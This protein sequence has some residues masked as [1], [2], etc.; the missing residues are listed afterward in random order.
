MKKWRYLLVVLLV[1]VIGGLAHVKVVMAE[2][3]IP[4][5][6]EYT[7]EMFREQ[8]PDGK[9]IPVTTYQEFLDAFG[10]KT[11]NDHVYIKVMN[12]LE[13]PTDSGPKY[14]PEIEPLGKDKDYRKVVVDG[15][16]G[17]GKNVRINAKAGAIQF[18]I[19]SNEWSDIVVQNVDIYSQNRSG[20]ISQ[21]YNSNDSQKL[22]MTYHNVDYYGDQALRADKSDVFFSGEIN[23]YG[24]QNYLYD[25]KSYKT[26]QK[27]GNF[28]VSNV[29]I[30]KKTKMHVYNELDGVLQIVRSNSTVTVGEAADVLFDVSDHP[31]SLAKDGVNYI[32]QH[33][34][35][36]GV[37]QPPILAFSLFKN[38][39]DL[40]DNPIQQSKLY[41]KD[42]SQ[43]KLKSDTIRQY[44]AIYMNGNDNLIDVGQ[45]ANLIIEHES[46]IGSGSNKYAKGRI[47]NINGKNSGVNVQEN[48]HFDIKATKRK[49]NT[50]SVFYGGDNTRLTVEPKGNFSISSDAN[51]TAAKGDT[52]NSLI[53]LGKNSTFNFNDANSVDL[54]YTDSQYSENLNLINMTT[55]SFDVNVQRVKAWA[56]GEDIENEGTD[57]FKEYSPMF[58]MKIPYK[59]NVVQNKDIIAA[60]TQKATIENFK[61]E[62][63]TTGG[64]GGFQRLKFEY[65]E[66]VS[67]DVT[68]QPT[69][70]TSDNQSKVIDAVATPGAHLRVKTTPVEGS[71]LLPEWKT[72]WNT[73][74]SPVESTGDAQFE[75]MTD[76]YTM[77][78]PSDGKVS[79]KLK[80]GTFNAGTKV[81]LYV[82][83]EGKTATQEI[84]VLDT[85]P[86]SGDKKIVNSWKGSNIPEPNRFVQHPTDTNPVPQEFQYQYVTDVNEEMMNEPGKHDVIVKLSDNAGNSTEINSELYIYDEPHQ[87]YAKDISVNQQDFKKALEKNKLEDW[88]IKTSEAGAYSIDPNTNDFV[89]LTNKITVK[90]KGKLTEKVEEGTYP[91]E[92]AVANPSMTKTINV[93]IHNKEVTMQVKQVYKGSDKP[94]YSNLKE[95]QTVKND[96]NQKQLIGESLSDVINKLVSDKK[97]ALNYDGYDDMS[98]KD[99]K[100][101]VDGKEV[102]TTQVPDKSFELVFEYQGK[103]TFNST[104]NVDFGDM[105]VNDYKKRLPKAE[106]KIQVINTLPDKT[107]QL[108]ASLPQGIQHNH[109]KK[110]FKGLMTYADDAGKETE[111]NQSGTLLSSS[112]VNPL[113]FEQDLKQSLSLKQGVGNLT[114]DYQGKIVWSL[115]DVPEAK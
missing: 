26:N 24:L 77:I 57:N 96:I 28:Q 59:K 93:V 85:T 95:K 5:S 90:D 65:I 114:G 49:G 58:E 108:K 68:S 13:N 11:G 3:D 14:L 6:Y 55:G 1:C 18:R 52:E 89:D 44:A 39:G 72:E 78:V 94:I 115:E 73:I 63:N 17:N 30:A 112:S 91:V 50:A 69:D 106:S 86:P 60:S 37:E 45:N 33:V 29:T 105:R 81:E 66:D 110:A 34:K 64:V 99:Y 10:G 56:R 113:L 43:L 67:V 100:V 15:N 102:K 92:L 101:L 19:H 98:Q 74:P 107:W 97:L 87:L 27:D 84:T 9:I 35:D 36:K 25:E 76:D 88:L 32:N 16:L 23:V 40:Q 42:N 2:E 7:E 12:D 70:N 103:M 75:K 47:V 82:F 41:L 61:K 79:L 21:H 83:R 4:E 20:F 104:S 48:G 71:T 80:E 8:Y 22:K 62:F 46:D 111:I 38:V 51:G 109:S 53:T 31:D 54:Q